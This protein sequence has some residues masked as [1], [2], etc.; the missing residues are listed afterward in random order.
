MSEDTTLEQMVEQGFIEKSPRI[1]GRWCLTE[2]GRAAF[3]KMVASDPKFY[4]KEFPEWIT[5]DFIH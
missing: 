4:A 5:I 3:E 2:K 1:E